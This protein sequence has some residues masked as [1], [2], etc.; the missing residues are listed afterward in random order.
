MLPDTENATLIRNHSAEYG[1]ALDPADIQ[2][3]GPN[4]ADDVQ[5]FLDLREDYAP[6]PLVPL[7][8]LA[9][10]LGI[11]AIHIKDEGKRLGLGSFKALGGAYATIRLA[12]EETA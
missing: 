2:T 11:H 4:A 5:R 8:A 10:A 9:G 6:T 3:L 1:R 12:V 7:P